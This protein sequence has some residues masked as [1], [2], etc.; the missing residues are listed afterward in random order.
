MPTR[1]PEEPDVVHFADDVSKE[2]HY[3]GE[4][5]RIMERVPEEMRQRLLNWLDDRYRK[6]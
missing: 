4:M 5:A 1:Q 6:D 3:M 2:L